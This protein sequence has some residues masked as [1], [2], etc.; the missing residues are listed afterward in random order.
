MARRVVAIFLLLLLFFGCVRQQTDFVAGAKIN[1]APPNTSVGV[2]APIGGTPSQSPFPGESSPKNMTIPGENYTLSKNQSPEERF[3]YFA[4]GSNLDKKGMR[5]RVGD[6]PI[7]RPAKLQ[8]FRR[9]FGGAADIRQREGSTVFGAIYFLNESQMKKLDRYEGAPNVYHRINVTVV[10]DG[11]QLSAVAY[12]YTKE[13]I[14]SQPSDGYFNTIKNGL[15]DHG[16]GEK[17]IDLLYLEA[18]RSKT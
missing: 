5:S 6:W 14:F 2:P 8:D 12:Q 3:W 11:E 18:N 17:E 1:D 4:F 9:T 16:Y 15:L 13:R 7:D 10:S